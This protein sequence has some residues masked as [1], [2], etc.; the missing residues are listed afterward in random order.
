MSS[1]AA[2]VASAPR[3]KI[4]FVTTAVKKNYDEMNKEMIKFE[5]RM[6]GIADGVP[7]RK[8][9]EARLA[10]MYGRYSGGE[11]NLVIN[12]SGTRYNCLTC[13]MKGVDDDTTCMRCW[14]SPTEPEETAEEAAAKKKELQAICRR[15][16]QIKVRIK[17]ALLE[18]GLL[19]T[20]LSAEW[21]Q[22]KRQLA[23]AVL[24]I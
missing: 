24:S 7:G 19:T 17:A 6:K 9:D 5:E 16:D 1:A 14:C 3:R 21:K 18:T 12:E 4:V 11:Q 20:A 23:M 10:S 22:I 2:S 13:G 8:A 15:Y